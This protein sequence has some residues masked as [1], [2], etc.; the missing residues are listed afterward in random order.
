MGGTLT[1]TGSGS[2]GSGG[3]IQTATNAGN[4]GIHLQPDTANLTVNLNRMVVQQNHNGVQFTPFST[5]ST[6]TL[7]LSVQDSSFLN[8]AASSVYLNP[9]GNTSNTYLIRNNSFTHATTGNGVT[10]EAL[11]PS[12]SPSVDQGKIQ[13]NT[14]SLSTGGN[15]NPIDLAQRVAGSGVAESHACQVE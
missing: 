3:V 12:G 1:V 2:A 14:L 13:N 15:A 4:I 5:A 7:N 8:N 9:T 10:Y 11:R 6:G